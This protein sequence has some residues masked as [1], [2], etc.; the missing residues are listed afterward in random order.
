MRDWFWKGFN[1]ANVFMENDWFVYGILY[2]FFMMILFLIE[3]GIDIIL[4]INI[5]KKI[6]I[7]LENQLRKFCIWLII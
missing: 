7:L 1:D 4:L 6:K 5:F 3:Y 2:I